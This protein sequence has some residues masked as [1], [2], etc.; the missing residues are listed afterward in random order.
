MTLSLRH[1]G[2]ETRA[3]VKILRRFIGG[4]QTLHDLSHS[5]TP[6]CSCARGMT[7]ECSGIDTRIDLLSSLASR[8]RALEGEGLVWESAIHRTAQ[9]AMTTSGIA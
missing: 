3:K 8:S 9:H 2:G 7:R 5:Q 6:V 1:D 4:S